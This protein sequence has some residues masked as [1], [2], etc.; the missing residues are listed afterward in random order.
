MMGKNRFLFFSVLLLIT[1]LVLA[2]P[3]G[4]AVITIDTTYPGG[5]HQ[6]IIDAGN[7]GTVILQP[8]T[9]TQHDIFIENNVTL[10]S[11]SGNPANT[12]I[13]ATNSGRIFVNSVGHALTIESLTLQNGA[14]TG[15]NEGGGIY[16]NGGTVTITGSTITGSTARYGGAISNRPGGTVTITGSTI[17]GC[18]AGYWGGA[19]MNYN[20]LIITG[21]TISDCSAGGT[22]GA[23]FN[24]NSNSVY[25]TISITNSAISGCTAQLGGAIRNIGGLI[26]IT[27]S[28][29]TGCTAANGGA[30][31]V[32]GL[33]GPVTIT[34]STISGCSATGIGGAIFSIDDPLT[35]TSSTITGCTAANGGGIYASGGATTAITDTTFSSC[36]ATGNGGAISLAGATTSISGSTFSNC[37]ADYGGAI[38]SDSSP[39]FSVASSRFTGCDATTG[40][41]AIAVSGSGA[42][43]ILSSDFESCSAGTSGGGA[44]LSFPST[45]IHFS[46]FHGNDAMGSGTAVRFV[47]T[48]S[49][50]TNNWWSSNSG[51]GPAYYGDPAAVA[52]WLVLGAAADPAVI[53]VAGTS[54]IRANLTFNSAG[55]D[56]SGSGMYL[57]DAIPVAFEMVSGPGSVSPLSEWTINS[58]AGTTYTS[59]GLG[60]ANISSTVDDQTVYVEVPVVLP[61]PI[62][63]GISPAGGRVTGG[64]ELVT[65]TGS[66]LTGTSVV[67]FG[68]NASPS[69][70]VD[71]D[72]QIR[73]VAPPNPVGT[74]HVIVTTPNGTSAAI[75]ADQYTYTNVPVVTSVTPSAGLSGNTLVT[76]SGMGFEGATDVRFGSVPAVLYIID[77]DFQITVLNP[78]GTAGS[79]VDVTVT[80]PEGTS[81]TSPADRFT[82]VS[83]AV[84]PVVTLDTSG[85]DDGFPSATPITTQADILT[86]MTVTVNIGGNSKAW[87]AV[88]TGTKLQELIVTGTVQPGSGSNTTAPP[89][90]V[91]QYINLVPARF[92]TITKAVIHFTVP[93]SWLDE[94]HIDPKNI[95]LY[96]QTVNGWE[97][98]PTTV[99]STK[100]GTVYFSAESNNFSLFAIAGTPTV[101]TPPG[102]AGMPEPVSTP[103]VQEQ[104][105]VPAAVAKAPV[106]THTTAPPV[107]SPVPG[108]SSSFPVVPALIGIGCVG[109][110]GGGWYVRRWWIRRQ[111]PALFREYD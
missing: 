42:P 111:N 93:Q 72:T 74:V 46:R 20:T 4:A 54:A 96:H 8:G 44:V 50:A 45:T 53:C 24:S 10:Q 19:I 59:A 60:T 91:F 65:I 32:Y 75:A 62:V 17:S 51:P 89:G 41:G 68:G 29:I 15:D 98:L 25:G 85:N 48:S 1:V 69:F 39:G 87:Q 49:D 16:N 23:I 86:P 107:P 110:I 57:P 5:I 88:V 47:S 73:A 83:P 109:L 78:T 35:I 80:T 13:D 55:T 33:F 7:E 9:Y 2:V 105:P 70:T 100:D 52:S 92:T 102:V 22:G 108:S 99:L 31:Y 71:M 3:A 6:A 67:M 94:N 30:I 40:G 11:E 66:N 58:V 106:T 37:I 82:F 81:A 61:E 103:A 21:S 63:T 97:A 12:I 27:S 56:T 38:N 79:T 77:N 95:V 36:T 26:T 104:V 28:T 101:L 76:I 18:S 90:M 84:A 14:V 34:S 43:S 64:G